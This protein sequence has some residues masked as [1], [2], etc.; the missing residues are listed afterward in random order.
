MRTGGHKSQVSANMATA[1]TI[2]MATTDTTPLTKGAGAD[3][4]IRKVGAVLI[5][6][7][8][9][10]GTARM[11]HTTISTTGGTIRRRGDAGQGVPKTPWTADMNVGMADH[12]KDATIATPLLKGTAHLIAQDTAI[13]PLTATDHHIAPHIVPDTNPRIGVQTLLLINHAMA[14]HSRMR[15]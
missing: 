11:I 14:N 8:A 10:R 13:G 15:M 1:P 3:T 6:R 2:T 5:T 4:I 9:I 12:R 7:E